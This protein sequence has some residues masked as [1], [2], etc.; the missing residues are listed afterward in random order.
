MTVL[1][2]LSVIG[3]VSAALLVIPIVE[4]IRLLWR[5]EKT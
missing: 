4:V 1:R 5:G 3:A 2:W